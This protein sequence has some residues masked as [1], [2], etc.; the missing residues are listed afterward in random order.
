MDKTPFTLEAIEKLKAKGVTAIKVELEANMSRYENEETCLKFILKQL[1]ED[2]DT[3][4]DGYD[5]LHNDSYHVFDPLPWMKFA[6]FYNDGSV[7]SEMT[8]T[9]KLDDP[10]NVF[11]IVDVI[12]AFKDCG[13]DMG[14]GLDTGGAGMHMALVFD[15]QCRYPASRTITETALINFRRAMKI[16]LPALYMLG[17]T[18]EETRNLDFRRPNISIPFGD[19]DMGTYFDT[20][21]KYSAI[22][23]TGNAMEF[24]VF[25]TCYHE[26]ELVYDYIQVMTNSIKYLSDTYIG[27]KPTVSQY[28]F[29]RMYVNNISS[30]YVEEVHLDLLNAG[31]KALKPS[32]YT[33]TQIKEQRNFKINKTSIKSKRKNIVKRAKVMYQE[34][35]DRY[36]FSLKCEEEQFKGSFMQDIVNGMPIAELR[37]MTDERLYELVK[38]K[39]E[40]EMQ[41]RRERMQNEERYI[42]NFVADEDS[43]NRTEWTINLGTA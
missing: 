35:A 11:K 29:G 7:D 9:V 10:N 13:N 25:D 24:R 28:R 3:S 22:H 2:Y 36:S 38:V 27:P 6:M 34:Y 21:Y 8:F 4:E 43:R 42:N 32:Y 14:D 20:G 30:L 37:T 12:N 41:R 15:E 5:E 33:I 16:H 19:P 39:V 17:T 1:D 26:P 31:L 23:F 18:N 40:E